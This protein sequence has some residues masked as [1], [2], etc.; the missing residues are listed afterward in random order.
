[1]TPTYYVYFTSST[2]VS[3]AVLFQGFSGT[4]IQI[5]TIVLGF[6][7]ICSGVVL[8]QLAKSSKDVPD[9]AVFTGDFNDI[10]TIAEQEQPE[11]EPK[12]DALRGTSAIIRRISVSRQK[13]EQ[14]EARRIRE[15]RRKDR[16]E[17][18]RPDEQV[19]WDGLR[20]RK[21]VRIDPTELQR[22]NSLHPPLGMSSFPDFNDPDEVE[23]LPLSP[24][25]LKSFQRRPSTARTPTGSG[26]FPRPEIPIP[27]A[28]EN[29]ETMEMGHVMGMPSGLARPGEE[30]HESK[31]KPI[32]WATDN[33][34]SSKG[35]LEPPTPRTGTKRQ[36][37][38]QN[39]FANSPSILPWGGG[40]RTP[41]KE[42]PTRLDGVT[43]EERLGLVVGDSNRDSGSDDE[44]KA[45]QGAPKS[46]LKNT[47]AASKSDAE[48]H[49]AG[50]QQHP[51]RP[52]YQ[53]SSTSSPEIRTPGGGRPLPQTPPQQSTTQQQQQQQQQSRQQQQQ[54]PPKSTAYIPHPTPQQ[55]ANQQRRESPVRGSRSGTPPRDVTRSRQGSQPGS[56]GSG[57]P[58]KITIN[59]RRTPSGDSNS[60][61]PGGAAF[62]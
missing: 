3:S 9:T 19:E 50:L 38:F 7:T 11:S 18:L 54:S 35:N 39:M 60:Q 24:A 27:E 26:T 29:K 46:I 12:A 22:R 21:T 47:G 42:H 58:P 1:V 32:T 17:S 45:A 62:I 4:P 40:N 33:A 43:E 48:V 34:S 41:T 44:K 20:R 15:D 23:R 57:S 2:I 59:D 10:R 51:P 28:D 14:D 31:G 53:Q 61:G 13:A 5:V 25:F 36:F 30:G 49:M 8:L 37:S 52:P 55:V 6:L 56:T 16:T